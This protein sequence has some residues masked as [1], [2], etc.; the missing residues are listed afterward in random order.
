[1]KI[2]VVGDIHGC[3]ETFKALIKK[4]DLEKKDR[5][6]CLGDLINRGPRSAE[7]LDM[8]CDDPRFSTILGNHDWAFILSTLSGSGPVHQD[9]QELAASPR[10]EIWISW[11]RNQPF[12]R[13]IENYFLVHAGCWPTW[14]LQEHQNCADQLHKWFKQC[15]VEE[16][17]ILDTYLPITHNIE[18]DIFNQNPIKFYAFVINVLTKIRYLSRVQPWK[19]EMN[20]KGPPSQQPEGVP[21]FEH[22]PALEGHTIV[23][24]HWSALKGLQRPGLEGLDTGCVWG[25]ALSALELFSQKRIT[26]KSLE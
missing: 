25:E 17:K 4:M 19:I 11:L 8:F 5:L 6:I 1:M 16:L 23:F 10:A 15:S 18:K 7:V 21:W 13:T 9:F 2:W 24:G 12:A 20:L 26:Q 22:A 3:Q 14:T